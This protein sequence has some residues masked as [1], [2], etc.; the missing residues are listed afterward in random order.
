MTALIVILCLLF[1]FACGILVGI[2]DCKKSYGIGKHVT[3]D[4]FNAYI[5]RLQE[6]AYD[7]YREFS[8]TDF[9]EVG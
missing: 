4:G 6:Q 2:A 7:P 8:D 3:P 9:D 1:G 5:E